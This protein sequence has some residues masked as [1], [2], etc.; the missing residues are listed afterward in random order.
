[1]RYV[2]AGTE[3]MQASGTNSYSSLI[4]YLGRVMYNYDERYYFTASV[5]VDGSSK[6][7][8]QVRYFPRCQ[9]SLAYLR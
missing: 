4:S 6:F 2:S 1:M 9:C 3:N 5:R 7:G 8:Q